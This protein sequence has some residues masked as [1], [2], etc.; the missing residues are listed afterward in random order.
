M[1]I[2]REHQS[3]SATTAWRFLGQD[4]V[5]VRQPTSGCSSGGSL[6]RDWLVFSRNWER[7]ADALTPSPAPAG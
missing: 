5:P 6:F 4:A 3:G 1:Q 2:A 7:S